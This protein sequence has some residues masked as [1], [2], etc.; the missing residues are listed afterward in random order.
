MKR[1][2]LIMTEDD[3]DSRRIMIMMEEDGGCLGSTLS[4]TSSTTVAMVAPGPR[5]RR[6]ML[7]RATEAGPGAAIVSSVI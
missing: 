3:Y 6:Q 2:M 1:L 4:V 7:A 5:G